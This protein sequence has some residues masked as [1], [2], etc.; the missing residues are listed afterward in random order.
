MAGFSNQIGKSGVRG[1]SSSAGLRK[2]LSRGQNKIPFSSGRPA[3]MREGDIEF[4]M[5]AGQGPTLFAHIGGKIAQW[6]GRWDR[7]IP[8]RS[9]SLSYL[10]FGYDAQ[11]TAGSS[12]GGTTTSKTAHTIDGS[13]NGQG[14]RMTRAG[15]IRRVSIQADVTTISGDV[16]TES[17]GSIS[18]TS[19]VNGVDAIAASVIGI[20]SIGDYGNLSTARKIAF[21]AG[22]RISVLVKAVTAPDSTPSGVIIAENYAVLV[23]IA[24]FET[25]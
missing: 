9:T 19:R 15:E 23:E 8:E 6:I 20:G 17:L 18:T 10:H 4:S 12:S 14:Y 5:V 7:D 22:D 2:A 24:L 11:I 16:A 21:A 13:E 25:D 3:G 1:G